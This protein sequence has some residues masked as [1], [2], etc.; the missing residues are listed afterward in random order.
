MTKKAISLRKKR[1]PTP[2]MILLAKAATG[3]P[4]PGK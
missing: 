3:L 2:A 1:V 4:F